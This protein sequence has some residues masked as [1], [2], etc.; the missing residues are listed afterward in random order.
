MKYVKSAGKNALVVA[1][2]AAKAA[3]AANKAA[4]KIDEFNAR[5]GRFLD[6]IPYAPTVAGI[7]RTAVGVADDFGQLMSSFGP[8]PLSHPGL[9]SNAGQSV[10]VS[11]SLSVKRTAPKFRNTRGSVRIVHKELVCQVWNGG[12]TPNLSPTV[13]GVSVLQVNSTCTSAFPWLGDIASHYDFY[14]FRRLRLVYVPLCSTATAGRVMIGYDPDSSDAIQSDRQALSSYSCSAESS[15]WAV[16][17]LDCK[18]TD[19]SRWYYAE[20]TASSQAGTGTFYDQGQFFVATW[21]GPDTNPV[22][23][24]YAL[25]DVELKDPQPTAGAVVQA[26]GNAGTAVSSFPANSPYFTKT[27]AATTF[28]IDIVAPGIH[29]INFTVASTVGDPS[30]AA[31]VSGGTASML[32]QTRTANAN[33][34]QYTCFV[35]LAAGVTTLTV[36]GLTALGHWTVFAERAATPSSGVYYY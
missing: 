5:N 17:S 4:K 36:A 12:S 19:T 35:Y 9:P 11:Q 13:N 3:A 28:A 18:L 33:T 26:Y 27:N 8:T 25:Y 2:S 31:V 14:R 22:G 16:S 15:S 21:G 29:F 10:G 30:P 1:Q 32:A 24:L 6:Y 7:A 20:A 23:E 34:V